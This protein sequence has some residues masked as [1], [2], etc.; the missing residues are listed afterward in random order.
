M[1]DRGPIDLTIQ[2]IKTS[3]NK[4]KR[5]EIQKCDIIPKHPF[6]AILSGRSGSGKSNLLINLL[7]QKHFYKNYFHFIFL[8]SPTAG[9]LDDSF[10]ALKKSKPK[11]KIAIINDLNPDTIENIMETNKEI[12]EEKGVHKAP[13]ILIVYDDV[14]SHKKFMNSRSFTQSFIASRHYNAS[15]IICTQRYNS[16]PRVARLQANAIFFFKGSNSETE[17]LS[18]EFCPPSFSKKEFLA[19][20]DYA[21]KEPYNFLFI[22]DTCKEHRHKYRKN[23]DQILEL[24]K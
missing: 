5:T 8:I 17:I 6:R 9:K 1:T 19:V 20:I 4:V 10:I 12:I 22:N 14:V 2:E 3:K 24:V 7:I 21:V 23:L 16:V 15:V 18:E 11:S 13:R